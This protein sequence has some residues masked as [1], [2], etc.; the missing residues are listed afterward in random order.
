MRH[1]V[2][3]RIVQADI[4]S[5]QLDFYIDT[6]DVVNEHVLCDKLRL[7]QIL[8]N[9]LPDIMRHIVEERGFRPIGMLCGRQ[10]ILKVNSLRFQLRLHLLFII[11]IYKKAHEANRGSILTPGQSA[12]RMEPSPSCILGKKTVYHIIGLLTG[13]K[14]SFGTGKGGQ[15]T[16]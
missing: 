1:I 10:S 9:L 3:E 4:M 14:D 13:S 12:G 5:K 2:E 16:A 7:N 15:G 8:L 11:N 6:V